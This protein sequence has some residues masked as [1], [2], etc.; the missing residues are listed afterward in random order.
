[1]KRQFLAALTVLS[2]F[3]LFG[4]AITPTENYWQAVEGDWN[5]SWDDSRHWSRGA[6]GKGQ[7]GRFDLKTSYSDMEVTFPSGEYENPGEIFL[8]GWDAYNGIVLNGTNT[9]YL[10]SGSADGSDIHSARP[11]N[12]QHGNGR[13]YD[14][15]F[16]G[17]YSLAPLKFENFKISWSSTADEQCLVFD[18]GTYNF[19]DPLGTVQTGTLGFFVGMNA[20]LST[21]RRV[22]IN[23]V[24]LKVNAINISNAES[25][26]GESGTTHN[27]VKIDAS[28]VVAAGKVSFPELSDGPVALNKTYSELL[29]DN[30][31]TLTFQLLDIGGV[32]SRWGSLS[33]KT[34][35]VTADHGSQLKETGNDFTSKD[36]HVVINLLNGSDLTLTRSVYFGYSGTGQTDINVVN[37]DWRSQ[38][39]TMYMGPP[40]AQTASYGTM[41]ANLNLTNSTFEV[42]SFFRFT[43][44]GLDIVDSEV[45]GDRNPIMDAPAEAISRFHAD[46][47]KWRVTGTYNFFPNDAA[48]DLLHDW[49]VATIGQKGFE[50]QSDVAITLSQDFAND[51]GTTGRLLLSGRGAK[52]LASAN[53]TVAEVAVAGGSVTFGADA[54]YQSALVV[55]NGASVGGVP[56][57]GLKGLV[58]GD[59]ETTGSFAINLEKT[60]DVAGGLVLANPL[61]T[62]GD[63]AETG[64][65]YV[66]FTADAASESTVEKWRNLAPFVSV[67]AGYGCVFAVSDIEDGRKAFSMTIRLAETR[68]ENIESGTEER[69]ADIILPRSDKVS[70]TVGE[71]AELTLSGRL[72]SGRFEKY[73]LGKTVL[74]NPNNLFVNGFGLYEGILGVT[75][76]GAFGYADNDAESTLAGGVLELALE[77]SSVAIRNPLRLA[78]PIKTDPVVLK[79]DADATIPAWNT[80]TDKGVMMKTGAGT[81]TVKA[82]ANAQIVGNQG[83]VG[84]VRDSSFDCLKPLVFEEDGRY[85]SGTYLGF[86]ITEGEVR[87][88][89]PQS[90]TLSAP[91][92]IGVGAPVTG[93]S[94][95]PAGVVIDGLTLDHRNGWGVDRLPLCSGLEPGVNCDEGLLNPYLCVTNHG[96]LL[97]DNV[98]IGNQ[99]STQEGG[100]YQ[101]RPRLDVVDGSTL[102]TKMLYMNQSGTSNLVLQVSVKGGSSLY[103]SGGNDGT[104]LRLAHSGTLTVDG[105]TLAA[106]ANLD[107]TTINVANGWKTTTATLNFLNGSVFYGRFKSGLSATYTHQG[108]MRMHFDDAEWNPVSDDYVFEPS[109]TAFKVEV[110]GRG[111]ILAPPAGGTWQW[112]YDTL[113]EGGLVMAGEGL[114]QANATNLLYTGV[115]E[116]ASGTLDLEGAVWADCVFAGGGTLV[117]VALTRPTLKVAVEDDLSA[118]TFLTLGEGASVSGRVTIDLGR[119]KPG[120][121]FDKTKAF[122]VLAYTGAAPDV[123][124]WKLVGTGIASKVRG[125][126]AA[127]AGFV[128]CTLADPPG[129]A[130]IVR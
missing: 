44:G 90:V 18:G 66:L 48:K 51:P 47:G 39:S 117:N 17:P 124:R 105:S 2:A 8:R 123:R 43:S 38:G 106:N 130:I 63:T 79:V 40:V 111:V 52:T 120:L 41:R 70:S 14:F 12:L 9:T 24:I 62:S 108:K 126:F 103:V 78:A 97:A 125:V 16:S 91:Y 98:M 95:R 73:G 101:L 45:Y 22:L 35:V 58:L 109:N 28:T 33:N 93:T 30:G 74:S 118:S 55:T 80:A 59:A 56:E 92:A 34:F 128:T 122:K 84:N 77:D 89:G 54:G 53:T 127:E 61:F 57:A 116:V 6:I 7:I 104:V 29:L 36:G 85:K 42:K 71:S 81:L 86:S 26:E 119:T 23:D 100:P 32:T 121:D 69:K 99:V 64:A 115:T 4:A 76:A 49:T 112:R 87:F 68:E 27:L 21:N 20:A 50:V 31:S 114:L 96:T 46:G 75:A 72:E 15:S 3:A 1:M 102:S 94:G 107:P 65:E 82:T 67:P 37:C 110:S 83:T 13:L 88:E 129:L 25:T 11:F 19:Y 113:G 60:V 10:M 5:G